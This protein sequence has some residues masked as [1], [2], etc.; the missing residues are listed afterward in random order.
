MTVDLISNRD[1]SEMK[2]VVRDHLADNE[3]EA[4]PVNYSPSDYA[5]PNS[6]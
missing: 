5:E 3:G 1:K 2:D 6:K 4:V